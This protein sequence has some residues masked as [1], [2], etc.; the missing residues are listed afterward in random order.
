MT[1]P[2]RLAEILRDRAAHDPAEGLD[3]LDPADFDWLVGEVERLRGL[4]KEMEWAG[5]CGAYDDYAACCPDC[6]GYEQEYPVPDMSG[7]VHPAG[8]RP[9]CELAAALA[10]RRS[11]PGNT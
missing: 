8:H 2:D 6:G 5:N 4:L 9:R 3:W 7:K 11:V 1:D 10:G